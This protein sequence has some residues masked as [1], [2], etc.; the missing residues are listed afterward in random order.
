[1]GDS[2]GSGPQ[3]RNAPVPP[4]ILRRLPAIDTYEVLAVD[5][6]R[7]DELVSNETRALGFGTFAWSCAL[8]SALQ[9]L[10][11]DNPNPK[12]IAFFLGIACPG[13]L[14]G[15]FFSVMW[16]R[17]HRER[18]RLIGRIKTRAQLDELGEHLQDGLLEG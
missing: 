6:D 5:L 4:V 11:M 13:V 16:Y 10:A 17:A 15:V 18:P 14:L 7:L 12:Q 1:M 3:I 8:S 9:W 2:S